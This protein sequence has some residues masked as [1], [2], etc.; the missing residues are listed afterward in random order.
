MN[1]KLQSYAEGRW[2]SSNAGGA[3]VLN[4]IT[5]DPG[6]RGFE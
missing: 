4:A 1:L 3:V 2:H 6:R 5:G